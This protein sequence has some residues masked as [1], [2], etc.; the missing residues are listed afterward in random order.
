MFTL[1]DGPLGTELNARGIE[2]CLPAWSAGALID[3][4]DVVERIHRD[5]AAAGARIHTAKYIFGTKRRTLGDRWEKLARRAV[6][7][8]QRALPGMRVAGSIAPLEDCYRPDL[9]PANSRSEHRELAHVLHSAG[10][11]ILLCETFP[12]IGEARIA[13]E[14]AVRTGTETWVGFTAGPRADLLTPN[15]MVQGAK[16]RCGGRSPS[17]FRQLYT[18]KRIASIPSSSS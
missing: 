4:P 7:I 10:C 3:A 16:K 11:D 2:T 13:V 12:H 5:Y 14:E 8:A 6:T 9:S 18:R 1:L 15:Q 17:R